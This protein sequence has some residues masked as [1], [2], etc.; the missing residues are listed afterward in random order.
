VEVRRGIMRKREEV[1]MLWR[2]K[3]KK[4]CV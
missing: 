4:K 1:A 3:G 2:G